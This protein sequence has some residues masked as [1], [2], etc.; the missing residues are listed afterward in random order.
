MPRPIAPQ[1]PVPEWTVSSY[2][3]END[4]DRLAARRIELKHLQDAAEIEIKQLD[5]EVGAMLATS[6]YKSVK[7][8][9]HRLTLGQSTAGGRLSKEL[10]LE[11]G[12]T[13]EQLAKGTTPRAPGTEYV[14]V[15]EL[16]GAD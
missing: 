12:V 2:L 5:L 16:K 3:V 8:G 11:A 4:F 14:S 10:L 1:E 7:F 15:T 13:P 9:Y 6:G